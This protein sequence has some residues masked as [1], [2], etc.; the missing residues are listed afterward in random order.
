MDTTEFYYPE[1]EDRGVKAEGL[2]AARF[3]RIG[4][5][6]APIPV[7]PKSKEPVGSGWQ[8][9]RVSEAALEDDFPPGINVGILLGEPSGGLI[10]IDLD[11]PEARDLAPA[12]LPDSTSVFG[13][14]STPQSHYLYQSDLLTKK[15]KDPLSGKMLVELRSTG[16]QTIF[17]GSVHPSGEQ[18]DWDRWGIV[19]EIGPGELSTAAAR[20]AAASLLA[21]HWPQKGSRHDA[22]LALSGMLS[23]AGWSEDDVADLVTQVARVAGDEEWAQRANDARSTAQRTQA[24]GKVTGAPSL[25]KL[26][27]DAV[28]AKAREWLGLGPTPRPANSPLPYSVQGGQ[29]IHR[30]QTQAG[31]V[32]VPLSNFSAQIVS[33]ERQDDGAEVSVTYRIKGALQ[34]GTPLAEIDVPANRFNSLNWVSESWGNRAV[35]FAGSGTKDHLR[36]AIQTLSSDTTRK[37][38]Y[39]HSGWRKLD[40]SWVYLHG[41]GA[42][43]AEGIREDI[44]VD[45]PDPLQHFKLPDSPSSIESQ[46]EAVRASL[47]ILD[48]ATLRISVP[49]LGA[50]YRSVVGDTDFSVYVAGRT[51]VGKSELAALFQQHFGAGFSAKALP[52][53]WA[54]TANS[55]EGLAFAAKDALLVLDDFAPHGTRTDIDKMH[56]DADRVLRA[57]GNRSG[58][59]RMRPDGS[60]RAV[61]P[62]RCLFLSTG[63]DV[64]K[65]QSLRARMVIVEVGP[66]DVAWESLTLLQSDAGNGL[67]ALALAGFIQWLAPRLE[68]AR[69]SI[70]ACVREWRKHSFAHRRSPDNLGQLYG[71]WTLFLDFAVSVGAVSDAVRL[72]SI[73]DA[74]VLVGDKQAAQLSDADPVNRFLQLLSSSLTSGQAHVA[75]ADQRK[76]PPHAE[77]WG[78]QD[79]SGEY[80]PQGPLVGWIRGED[81]YLD[82]DAAFAAAQKMAVQQGTHLGITQPT[83]WKSMKE[84][85]LLSSHDRE[86]TTARRTIRGLQTRVIHIQART[87]DEQT[88]LAQSSPPQANDRATKNGSNQPEDTLFEGGSPVRPVRPVIENKAPSPEDSRGSDDETVNPQQIVSYTAET[89]LSGLTGLSDPKTDG[90]VSAH[91]N[92]QPSDDEQR[93][94]NRATEAPSPSDDEGEDEAF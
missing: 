92:S 53:S 51:G 44:S 77:R 47:R 23:H 16:T 38:V 25:A 83:L 1:P 36:C 66:D 50:V 41:A 11:C 57:Q 3:Y 35:V 22:A 61:K 15:F 78:W 46:Q 17:P 34:D 71:A 6:W 69:K 4:P 70:K 20:L 21:L 82:G 60:L 48:V 49:L 76:D 63:E 65:G 87:L 29:T 59:G 90:T 84:R 55:N 14:S 26:I 72:E 39:T 67:F 18:I 7:K 80:V 52:G 79:K 33:E 43:G 81:L 30:R 74:L 93:A 64:P 89:G 40:G 86:R 8:N 19:A 94:T 5:R 56:K 85:K 88:T 13:R 45:L 2:A 91:P 68:E 31:S 12:I 37:T 27:P 42:I 54:S 73:R 9:R 24:G 58:R 28:V 32:D 75:Y 62:P 10:D